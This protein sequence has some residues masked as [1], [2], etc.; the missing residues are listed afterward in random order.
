MLERSWDVIGSFISCRIH[1]LVRNGFGSSVSRKGPNFLGVILVRKI[2]LCQN[3]VWSLSKEE[4]S[5]EGE[6]S[7]GEN[8]LSFKFL[9]RDRGKNL[10]KIEMSSW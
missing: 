1:P 7:D 10:I 6:D 3:R 9:F 8:L 2:V 5:T 4:V